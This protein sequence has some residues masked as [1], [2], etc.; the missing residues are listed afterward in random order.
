VLLALAAC[1]G[2][3]GSL[4][5]GQRAFERGDHDRALAIFRDL[6][7]DLGRLSPVERTR[8]AYLRGMTDYRLGDKTDARH[9][10]ALATGR[11]TWSSA[12]AEGVVCTSGHRA[13]EVGRLL[14]LVRLPRAH[15]KP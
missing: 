7:P 9:W 6:E 3:S 1:S 10:L 11:L 8:Y 13:G 5:R 2:A 14:P 12:V 4:I 15:N